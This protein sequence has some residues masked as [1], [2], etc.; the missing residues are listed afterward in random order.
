MTLLTDK[1]REEV[2]EA[3]RTKRRE[4]IAKPLDRIYGDLLTA[5]LPAIERAVLDGIGAEMADRQWC[6]GMK[7]AAAMLDNHVYGLMTWPVSE[8]EKYLAAMREIDRRVAVTQAAIAESRAERRAL[9]GE[10]G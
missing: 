2:V 7:T 4:L 6:E 3:M 9:A 10:V 1:Q 8:Q 5:A